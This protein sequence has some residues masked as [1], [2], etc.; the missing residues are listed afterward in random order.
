MILVVILTVFLTFLSCLGALFFKSELQIVNMKNQML[1][2]NYED[3]K[4]LH[5]TSMFTYHD[6]KNHILVLKQYADDAEIEKIPEYLV[7]I[8]K[9]IEELSHHI[10]CNNEVVNP[11]LNTKILEAGD[12]HIPI[13]TE[14]ENISFLIEDR[15]LCI[16][17]ANLIENAAI[18]IT[19]GREMANE[20]TGDHFFYISTEVACPYFYDY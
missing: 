19:T 17:L 9:P 13:M 3:I 18:Y 11:I 20:K 7:N 12:R 8:R 15:D 2:K 5:E 1:N 16:I 10:W 14:I 4:R 6:L